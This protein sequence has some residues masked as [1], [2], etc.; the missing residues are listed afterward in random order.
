[1]TS[2]LNLDNKLVSWVALAVLVLIIVILGAYYFSRQQQA[3]QSEAQNQL[4]AIQEQSDKNVVENVAKAANPFKASNPL[5]G[6]NLNPVEKA[7]RV[8]NPFD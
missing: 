8:L 1:M 4:Q 3:P 2:G 6:I 5:E 7:E